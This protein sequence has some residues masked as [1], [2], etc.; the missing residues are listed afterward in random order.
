LSDNAREFTSPV[1]SRN[2]AAG[3]KLS[4]DQAYEDVRRVRRKGK[5]SEEREEEQ[6]NLDTVVIR[7]G[8]KVFLI[9]DDA[10]D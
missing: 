3:S 7:S 10:S 8:E 6:R 4:I 5:R 9:G 1:W 2:W